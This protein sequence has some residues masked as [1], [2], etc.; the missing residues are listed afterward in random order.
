MAEHLSSMDPVSLKTFITVAECRS[1]SAAAE[2][3]HMTQPAISKRVARLEQA[4]DSPLFDRVGHNIQLTNAGALLLQQAK[5]ILQSIQFTQQT[6]M[7]LKG[8]AKGPLQIATG[9]HIG[10]YRLPAIWRELQ[11]LFPEIDLNIQFMDSEDAYQGIIDGN[12][13]I[14]VLTL[15]E[16]P[17]PSIRTYEIWQDT[18][19]LFCAKDSDLARHRLLSLEE[20]ASYPVVLPNKNTFTRLKIHEYFLQQGIDLA[21]VKTGDYLETIKVLVECN[22]GWSVLP[23]IM[24][25]RNLHKLDIDFNLDRSL[26]LIH[27]QKRP[28]SVAG[29]EF[30]RLL[31]QAM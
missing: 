15:P 20:L 2:S 27:H 29:Q 23:D 28:L 3:L 13:E 11:K 26:G 6:I 22:L 7:N 31:Q 8:A 24:S 10:M 19:S 1:F 5:Q 14:A 12:I 21:K 17:H 9:H 25:N 16:K 4:L 30:L 18:L